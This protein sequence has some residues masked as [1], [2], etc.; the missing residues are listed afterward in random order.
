[1][2]LAI[3]LYKMLIKM[4]LGSI[5]TEEWWPV[6][7]GLDWPAPASNIFER[8]VGAVLVQNTSWRN[9]QRAIENLQSQ[10]LLNTT[11]FLSAS[12]AVIAECVRPAGFVTRKPKTLKTLASFLANVET[13]E[14]TTGEL[15]EKLLEIK[16]IGP[17]TADTL[18]LFAFE[19]PVLPIS[20][21][22]LRVLSRF[23]NIQINDREQFEALTSVLPKQVMVL[24]T[25]HALLVEFASKVCQKNRPQCNC[26]PLKRT[27]KT[28]S[29]PN[30]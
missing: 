18:L 11:A 9:V 3:K 21:P 17:E 16:G 27:C 19:R 24:R 12:E 26:C 13:E 8:A 10:K 6:N 14:L 7:G 15:R 5:L 20:Q 4:Y 29:T 1:M 25:F 28:K 23:C 2:R 22:A 30:P